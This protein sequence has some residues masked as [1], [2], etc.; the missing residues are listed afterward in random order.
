MLPLTGASPPVLHTVT[1]TYRGNAE[2]VPACV[3]YCSVVVAMTSRHLVHGQRSCFV[4][5]DARR[6]AERLNGLEVLDENINV[7]HLHGSQCESHR[8]L[9]ILLQKHIEGMQGAAATS[10]TQKG[11]ITCLRQQP[12]GNVGDDDADG[13]NE[14]LKGGKGCKQTNDDEVLNPK[15]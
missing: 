5:G 7:L 9:S 12:L 6:A 14:R 4:A 3:V 13:E 11:E 8:E 1:K 15:P 2:R 10:P